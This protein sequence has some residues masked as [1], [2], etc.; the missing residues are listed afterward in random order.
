MQPMATVIKVL[1]FGIAIALYLDAV[2]LL[3]GPMIALD[4]PGAGRGLSL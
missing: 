3:A 2:P 4:V 1:T